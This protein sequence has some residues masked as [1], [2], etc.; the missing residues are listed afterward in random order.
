[1]SPS[2][3]LL[4]SDAHTHALAYGAFAG[5][6]PITDGPSV[7]WTDRNTPLEST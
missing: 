3:P 4:I 7:V 5:E 2:S 1:M 6:A